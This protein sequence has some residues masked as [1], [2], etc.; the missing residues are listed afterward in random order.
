MSSAI[1]ILR[2]FIAKR[3]TKVKVLQGKVIP[4]VLH[5]HYANIALAT[6]DFT[7]DGQSAVMITTV[8]TD[9]VSVYASFEGNF[10]LGWAHCTK[11]QHH[12]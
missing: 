6:R 8:R 12:S 3:N 5:W 4:L 11:N 10:Q 7:M 2:L 9:E 1:D